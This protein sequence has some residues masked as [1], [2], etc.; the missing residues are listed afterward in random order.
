MGA[1]GGD[2]VV[3]KMMEA[4]SELGKRAEQTEATLARV[5]DHVGQLAED[6]RILSTLAGESTR[7]VGKLGTIIEVGLQAQAEYYAELEARVAALEAAKK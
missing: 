6:V 5:R 4:V 3:L 1:W 7:A 2:K